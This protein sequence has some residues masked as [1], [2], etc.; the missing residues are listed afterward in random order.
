MNIDEI[1]CPP[2][3]APRLVELARALSDEGQP[4]T[5][6][7]VWSTGRIT[8]TVAD[9]EVYLR[10]RFGPVSVRQPL[11]LDRRDLAPLARACGD[12]SERRDQWAAFY[13]STAGYPIGY[14]AASYYRAPGPNAER[15]VVRR[16]VLGKPSEGE[17]WRGHEDVVP[18]DVAER[19][20]AGVELIADVWRRGERFG[21]PGGSLVGVCYRVGRLHIHAHRQHARVVD[22]LI[23][24][25]VYLEPGEERF[26]AALARAAR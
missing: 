21:D 23:G 1:T 24:G 6:G 22:S 15:V 9:R 12:W 17:D 16:E 25:E 20:D 8:A 4:D 26:V 18:R 14:G 19:I 2:S 7:Y 11:V 5:V 3:S 10:R 13:V